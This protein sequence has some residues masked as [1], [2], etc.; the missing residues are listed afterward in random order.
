L[1]TDEYR[2]MTPP[3]WCVGIGAD[4]RSCAVL[5]L[6]IHPTTQPYAG[7]AHVYTDRVV[8]NI[9]HDGIGMDL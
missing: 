4:I 2:E 7:L 6:P 5:L 9:F 1:G 3:I 8:S